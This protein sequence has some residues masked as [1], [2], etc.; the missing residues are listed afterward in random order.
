MADTLSDAFDYWGGHYN[1]A[2]NGVAATVGVD[3]HAAGLTSKPHKQE[4]RKGPATGLEFASCL[5]TDGGLVMVQD[6]PP[7]KVSRPVRPLAA[8][9]RSCG[10]RLTGHSRFVATELMR[11]D[12]SRGATTVQRRTG[13]AGITTRSWCL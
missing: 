5:L 9:T 8:C 7:T 3:A 12:C 4:Q 10:R 6:L 11:G 13:G 2:V 1:R